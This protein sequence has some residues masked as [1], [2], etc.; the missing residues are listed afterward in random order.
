MPRRG[1][2]TCSLPK[3]PLLPGLYT[4]NAYCTVAGQVAD[5]VKD[6]ATIEVLEGDYFGTGKL[7]LPGYGSTVI[8]HTWR[9]SEARNGNP[10]LGNDQ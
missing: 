6:A 9:V 5:W 4:L 1:V 2:I 10:Q 8:A 7:P 3:A